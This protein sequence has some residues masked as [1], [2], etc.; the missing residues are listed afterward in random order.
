ME[1]RGRLYDVVRIQG[2]LRSNHVCQVKIIVL[3]TYCAV[4]RNNVFLSGLTKKQL[5]VLNLVIDRLFKH[6]IL[7]A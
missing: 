2:V 5:V 6:V 3:N 1:L 7:N 4:D